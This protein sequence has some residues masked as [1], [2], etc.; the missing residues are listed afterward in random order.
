MTTPPNLSVP[1]Y[2]LVDMSNQDF[3]DPVPYLARFGIDAEL[4]EETTMAEA[5]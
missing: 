4:V 2:R 1:A 3:T 5:A